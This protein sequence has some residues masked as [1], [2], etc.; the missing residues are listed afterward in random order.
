MEKNIFFFFFS[1]VSFNLA[2]S[3]FLTTTERD[4]IFVNSFIVVLNKMK[5]FITQ[6]FYFPYA[7]WLWPI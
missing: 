6:L 1:F 3:R 7:P 4:Y 2:K 5:T